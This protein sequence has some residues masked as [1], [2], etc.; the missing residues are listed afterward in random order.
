MEYRSDLL[1]KVDSLGDTLLTLRDRLLQVVQA[2][3]APGMPPSEEIIEQQRAARH[4]FSNVR[5]AVVEY[6]KSIGVLPTPEVDS[7]TTTQSLKA[8]LQAAEEAE[9]QRRQTEAVRQQA[10]ASVNKIFRIVHRDTSEFPALRQC[11]AHADA[12]RNVIA[13]PWTET[14]SEVQALANGTHP[15]AALLMFVEHFADLDDEQWEAFRHHDSLLFRASSRNR[16]TAPETSTSS[17]RADSRIH[18][19]LAPSGEDAAWVDPTNPTSE[20]EAALPLGTLAQEE[21]TEAS[22]TPYTHTETIQATDEHTSQNVLIE[23]CLNIVEARLHETETADIHQALDNEPVS[24]AS[25]SQGNVPS[26]RGIPHAGG[27]Q[28]AVRATTQVEAEDEEPSVG[29]A[30]FCFGPSDTAQY[31]A[32][33]ILS[34]SIAD[35]GVALRD[36]V[37]RLLYEDKLALAFHTAR[38]M[39]TSYPDLQ[40]V[41]PPWLVHALALGRQICHATGTM[42]HLLKNDFV[43]FHEGVFVPRHHEWNHAVRFLLAAAALRPALL[44]PNTDAARLLHT[45]RMKEG[46]NTLWE[47]CEAIADYGKQQMPLD[48]NALKQAKDQAAWQTEMA[49]LC[50]QVNTWCTQAPSMTMVYPPATN[51]WRHWQE[52]GGLIHALLLPVRQND[53]SRV[54]AVKQQIELFSNDAAI[55]KYINDTDRKVLKRRPGDDIS[56]KARGQLYARV[57]EAVELARHWVRLSETSLAHSQRK[58]YGQ[59]QAEQISQKVLRLQE[60]VV[61]ELAYFVQQH[62]SPGMMGSVTACRRVVEDIGRLFDPH[63]TFLYA[64]PLV[65]HVLQADFLRIPGL[66]LNDEWEPATYESAAIL[67]MILQLIATDP[68]SWPQALE[69]QSEK[70]NHEATARIIEYLEAYPQEGV[71]IDT[72]KTSRTKHLDDCHAALRRDIESTRHDVNNALTFGWLR[73]SEFRDYDATLEN[74]LLSL[75]ETVRFVEKHAELQSMR[76]ALDEK[77]TAD[78]ET[79]WARLQTEHIS[80]EHP[81][82][83]R[84]R[85][86]L[87]IG[88][89]STANEYIDMV[90][91]ERPLPDEQVLT[92]TFAAVFSGRL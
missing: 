2:L 70:R 84:I 65:P 61:E 52:T 87:E 71:S 36:L 41:L 64:E 15:L 66:M 72:L 56:A 22:A 47:Y 3:Q 69:A 28:T 79:A 19:S 44:A 31:I 90:S 77:R 35:H 74:M 14:P 20:N 57:R 78:V 46:L 30:P 5:D 37:W 83:D 27:P 48:P 55:K 59:Q 82:H 8:L 26:H 18:H 54:D 53:P 92:N 91:H 33:C 89:V 51:V 10:L 29:Q 11:Y 60:A 40:P 75:E 86:V 1:Q 38:Y 34:G 73:E 63:A 49:S 7:L 17:R 88:D 9:A 43:Q 24:S 62:P 39:E 16:C 81:A 23:A 42:A 58:T 25:P 21:T 76:H 13:A 32:T 12:L 67:D 80:S 50:Q 45:L 6:T 4:T 85:H 68:C